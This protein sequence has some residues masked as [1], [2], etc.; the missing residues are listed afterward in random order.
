MHDFQRTNKNVRTTSLVV[1]LIF[2]NEKK[3]SFG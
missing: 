3:V 2:D 1:V